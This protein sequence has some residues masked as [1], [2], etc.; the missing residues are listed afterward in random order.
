MNSLKTWILQTLLSGIS[1]GGS[2]AYFSGISILPK[3]FTVLATFD[4][5]FPSLASF[6]AG[7]EDCSAVLGLASPV[8]MVSLFFLPK[9]S[10]VTGILMVTADSNALDLLT[11]I[12]E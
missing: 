11:F 10:S 2:G 5:Q 6:N 7:D 3:T 4:L 8:S 9:V 12:S 1:V